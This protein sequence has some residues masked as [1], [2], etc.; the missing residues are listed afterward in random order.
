[1]RKGTWFCLALIAFTFYDN[2]RNPEPT[3]ELFWP[4]IFGIAVWIAIIE[5]GAFDSPDNSWPRKR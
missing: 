4:F 2:A 3:P 1:M 5:S